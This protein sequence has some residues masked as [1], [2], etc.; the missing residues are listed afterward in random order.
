MLA[1][2]S[3]AAT[4]VTAFGAPAQMQPPSVRCQAFDAACTA[5]FRVQ[6]DSFSFTF[7]ARFFLSAVHSSN[8]QPIRTTQAFIEFGGLGLTLIV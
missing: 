3:I 7:H 2:R 6:I 4:N 8:Q 1:W 5:W